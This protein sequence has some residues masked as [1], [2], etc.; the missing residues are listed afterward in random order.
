[1]SADAKLHE[2]I[3]PKAGTD[4]HVRSRNSGSTVEGRGAILSTKA[5]AA[6]AADADIKPASSPGAWDER[7]PAKGAG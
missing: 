2:H 5:R 4:K 1:M 3:N 7:E 6:P